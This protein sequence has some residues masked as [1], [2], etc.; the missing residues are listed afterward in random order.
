MSLKF[1]LKINCIYDLLNLFWKSTKVPASSFPL[2]YKHYV[3]VMEWK[4]LN[5]V[6]SAMFERSVMWSDP[7]LNVKTTLRRAPVYV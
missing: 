4:V 6:M 1:G 3:E 7:M 2:V 5:P